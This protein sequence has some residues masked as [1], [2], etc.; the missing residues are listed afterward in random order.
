MIDSRKLKVFLTVAHCES[1]TAA[2][3]ILNTVQSTIS[4][5]IRDLEQDLGCVLFQKVGKRMVITDAATTLLEYGKKIEHLMIE[6]RDSVNPKSTWGKRRF[7]IGASL[8]ASVNFIPE[9]LRELNES[10][11]ICT[12]S[13]VTGNAPEVMK[14]VRDGEVNIAFSLEPENEPQLEFIPVFKDEL[15]WIISPLHAWT[16]QPP[17]SDAQFKNQRFVI[18]D[19]GSYTCRLVEAFFKKHKFAPKSLSFM[20]SMEAMKAFVK[21]G[22]GIGMMPAW[23]AQQEINTGTLRAL[24][25]QDNDLKRRWGVVYR[26]SITL[27]NMEEAFLQLCIS[28]IYNKSLDGYALTPIPS[29]MTV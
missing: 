23:I 17:Y 19:Q 16:T 24:P 29:E 26:K 25:I 15:T 3:R 4:H 9:V 1:Y 18:F 5:S 20:S 27:G 6:A 22:Q 28:T 14:A 2:A 11:P 21:L 13:I 7:S 8:S 10:F 12:T